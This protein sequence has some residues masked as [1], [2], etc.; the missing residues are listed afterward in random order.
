MK[1]ESSSLDILEASDLRNKTEFSRATFG[2]S[3]G[4][5]NPNL[6]TSTPSGSFPQYFESSA[7]CFFELLSPNNMEG[8]LMNNFKNFYFSFSLPS[9]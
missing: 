5:S 7:L 6:Q 8:Y 3:R 2:W 4:D 1:F 9:P